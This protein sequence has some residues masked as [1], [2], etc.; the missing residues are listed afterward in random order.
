MSTLSLAWGEPHV[1]GL[2]DGTYLYGREFDL[3]PTG[4]MFSAAVIL[5]GI[6]GVEA[7]MGNDNVARVATDAELEL[8]SSRGTEPEELEPYEDE[9]IE[10]YR[11]KQMQDVQG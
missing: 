9:V 4:T 11:I 2:P 1:F 6:A 5:H 7:T 10:S 8:Y 3:L